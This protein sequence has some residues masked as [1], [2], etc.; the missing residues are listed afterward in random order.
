MRWQ[1]F[2]IA[3]I[4]YIIRDLLQ[5]KGCVDAAQEAVIMVETYLVGANLDDGGAE[6]AKKKKSQ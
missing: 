1:R 5:K 2:S 4:H 3:E 6:Q